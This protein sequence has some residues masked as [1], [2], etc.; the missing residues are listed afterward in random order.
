M[1]TRFS[2]PISELPSFLST[3]SMVSDD[4]YSIIQKLR[5]A[6]RK[7][8]SV[9]EPTRALFLA[10]LEG[11]INF[12][13]A[14][15]QAWRIPDETEKKCATQVLYASKDFLER[16]RP[17]H[18]AALTGLVF[19]LPNGLPLS[20]SP[21]WIR[22]CDPDRILVLHFWQT[23]FSEWQLSAAA[24]V[25]RHALDDHEYAAS[26]IDFISVPFSE[27]LNR[28]RFEI[29]NW[30]TLKPLQSDELKRFWDRFISAWSEYQYKGPRAIK[31]R[32]H[33]TLF[34]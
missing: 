15:Q 11:K 12:E 32:R 28:R 14:M 21:F 29:Y 25:L 17:A 4:K 24:A 27:A 7:S 16:Q 31:V 8:P 1:D 19:T 9:Y 3:I 2:T 33:K 22:Q 30:R 13:K 20:V 34:D 18:V 23:A 10:T 26:E 6:E 5:D